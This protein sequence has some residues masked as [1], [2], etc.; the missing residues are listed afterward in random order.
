MDT[1][2]IM[3][4][5]KCERDFK[6]MWIRI[7]FCIELLPIPSKYHQGDVIQSPEARNYVA[8]IPVPINNDD[9]DEDEYDEDYEDEEYYD[10]DYEDEEDEYYE[11]DDE[12]VRALNFYHIRNLMFN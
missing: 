6:Q 3:T 9:E 5:L 12:E 10:E 8:Y 11:D 2:R 1:R 7:F 4:R